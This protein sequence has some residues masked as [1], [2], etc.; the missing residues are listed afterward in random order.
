[1]SGRVLSDWLSA[2]APLR[3]ATFDAYLDVFLKKDDR[4]PRARLATKSVMKILPDADEIMRREACRLAAVFETI[5]AV[6][7]ARSTAALLRLGAAM[8]SAY[9][10]AKTAVMRLDYDD[11]I[12]GARNLLMGEDMTPWV[13]FKL[14][15]GLDHIL[16]DESQDTN[17]EQW[18]IVRTIAEEF[19]A[20]DGARD[21]VARTIFSVGD[22]KQS[23]FSFQRADPASG[24]RMRA[25]FAERAASAGQTWRSI[26]LD[27]S[28]RST[29]AVLNAVDA[30]FE[31][32]TARI[33][34]VQPGE[35]LRH[36]VHRVG[37]AG[38]VEVWPLVEPAAI[39]TTEPWSPPLTRRQTDDP[40]SRLAEVIAARIKS[41]I[42]HEPLAARGE[43]V[44]A[45]DVMIL[46]R[47]RRRI[48][49][50][51]VRALK[52][53][54]VPV[55]GV[56]RLVLTQQLAVMDLM[57]LANFLLLPDDDL[58]LAAVL[59]GPLIGFDDDDLFALAH[60]RGDHSLW[61]RLTDASNTD[62]RFAAAR[63]WL[64]QQLARVDFIP[65]YELFAD[66]LT[67]PSL[68]D[69]SGRQAMIARLGAEAED[70]LDEFLNLALAYERTSAPSLQGFLHWVAAEETEVKRDLE[71]SDRDEVRVMTV[72]GAKGLQA[73]IVILADTISS[74]RGG[75]GGRS[76]IYWDDGVPL[77]AP[78]RA[79]ETAVARQVREAA[80]AAEAEEYNRLLYVAMTRAEDRLYICGARGSSEPAPECWYNMAV[81]GVARI[82]QSEDFNFSDL[83]PGGWSGGG[84]AVA[85][86]QSE[87][88]DSSKSSVV[89][90]VPTDD[91]RDWMLEIA[92]EEP[93]PPQPLAPSRPG[94]EEP[95]VRS[96]FDT[97][98][99]NRFRRG[100]LVH[101]LL[102]LLPAVVPDRRREIS[103]H[104]LARP[105]HNLDGEARI[106]LTTEVMNVLE[107][108]EF[109][110]IF[111]PDSRAEVSL[112]GTV[113]F[114]ATAETVS[115]Q[116]DRLVIT[117]SEIFVVDYK[118]MRPVP[119]AAEF[120][121][122]AYLRQLAIYRALLRAVWPERRFRGA[123]LWTEGPLLM[124]IDDGLLDRHTPAS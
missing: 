112:A 23:I 34:V 84:L 85:S 78:R 9:D 101:R 54:D 68:L 83:V 111:G 77:W 36:N 41:W 17:P 106:Q 91:L 42:G 61:Q 70:P 105:V 10:A 51:L 120:V 63:D 88:P 109:Q 93:T 92:P 56:D 8:L 52:E 98:G 116:V 69:R 90:P 14:D 37:A 67:R 115:G 87:H 12:Y 118:T 59:K 95:S 100:L 21:D 20:G 113:S 11:L 27:T 6:I 114:G 28:F 24:E 103:D 45:G 55:A 44:R 73:P 76:T 94:I 33:G 50:R 57:A 48:V 81:E 53:V 40:E 35:Q 99:S 31:G 89:S 71:Q 82:G 96:P 25:H 108:P 72:H 7:S 74:P 110:V 32:E 124:P 19:F 46:V 39:E 66:V 3:E 13:L 104:F 119:S 86:K 43:M 49:D 75:M 5:R 1:M 26:Q 58:T 79:M 80:M 102:E 107:H 47:R 22:N 62:D 30:V 60:G 29:D 123:L 121:P 117:E 38:R 2:E 97:T 64:G 122:P 4:Q 65:P 15:G 18:D 16:I